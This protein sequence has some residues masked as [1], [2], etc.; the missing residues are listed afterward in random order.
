MPELI[1]RN[2]IEAI[3]GHRNHALEL[4]TA[5]ME[6]IQAAADAISAAEAAVSVACSDVRHNNYM[7]AKAPEIDAFHDAVKLPD[8]D[9][10][11]RVARRLTDIQVWAALIART[12]MEHLM[13]K[14]AKDELRAQMTYIPENV[15][16]E[17]GAVINEE[18]IARGLPPVDVD[19]IESTLTGLVEDAGAIFRRGIANAFSELDRRFRSHDGFKIGSRMIL[20]NAFGD[21][22]HWSYYRNHRDTLTDIERVFLV[23]DGKSP[24]ANYAGIVGVIEAGRKAAGVGMGGKKTEHEGDYFKVRVFK[25]GNAHLWFTRKDLLVK[26]N[27]LLAEHY[28]AAVGDGVDGPDDPEAPMKNR[29]VGH[30]RNFGFFPTPDK[31]VERVIEEA[32]LINEHRE[33]RFP[34]RVL[35]PS[36]GTGALASRAVA[37]GCRVDVIEIQPEL[38]A[39]LESQCAYGR[40]HLADFLAMPPALHGGSYDRVIMNPPFD[41]G[42]DVDHVVH[43]WDFVKPGG[44]LV[45]V[46]S[47]GTEFRT[48]KKTTAFREFVA[49]ERGRFQD[50]PPGS[51]SEVG[52]NVNTVLLTLSKKAE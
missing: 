9:Q 25:N 43:A 7:D 2:T 41:R 10:Y 49:R 4:Y 22:G 21:W 8:P 16:R 23:L 24:R 47:A 26:V 35:E 30:A 50:L 44:R 28:G 27:K 51:F 15:D 19:V 14:Q 40:V 17:T 42:R 37:E 3:V 12:D 52:T 36:A 18:E 48:D 20:D 33:Q 6:K 13:D 38:A 11:L 45:A 39:D 31:V 34:L 29:A 46:M 1:V 32:Y 5:A